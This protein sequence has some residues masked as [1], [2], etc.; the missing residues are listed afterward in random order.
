ML[1]H[2]DDERDYAERLATAA[3]LAMRRSSAT[4][5]LTAN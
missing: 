3:G 4:A 2:F 1:L 5:F